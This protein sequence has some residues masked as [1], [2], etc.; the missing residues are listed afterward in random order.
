MCEDAFEAASP[1]DGEHSGPE[2]V[3][4]TLG[5]FIAGVIDAARNHD[6]FD[7]TLLAI[8]TNHIVKEDPADN[9]VA[10]AVAQIEALAESRAVS[11]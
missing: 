2:A 3:A 1:L 11:A 5:Q 4:Q 8:L 9:A 10:L 6:D 7:A